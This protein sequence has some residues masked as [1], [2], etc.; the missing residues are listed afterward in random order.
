MLRRASD[1]RLVA[2]RAAANFGLGQPIALDALD[3]LDRQSANSPA[4]Q[5]IAQAS[6]ANLPAT[7][8]PS[9]S[10]ST[11]QGQGVYT[12]A[13]METHYH[14]EPVRVQLPIAVSPDSLTDDDDT[15]V[16]VDLGSNQSQVEFHYE[17]ERFGTQPQF[18]EPKDAWSL[19]SG[20]KA[21]LLRHYSRMH[22]PTVAANSAGKFYR[23]EAYYLYAL[24]R[25]PKT[26]E[27]I[28][29]GVLPALAYSQSDN[30][31]QLADLYDATQAFDAA[32]NA[33]SQ[34]GQPQ[35]GESSGGDTP[36]S[37]ASA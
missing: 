4:T 27:T 16:V 24:N 25:P 28:P 8:N 36:T 32:G 11:A 22:P 21:S 34:Q 18:P 12:V 2:L 26:N 19:D 35:G 29:V 14:R 6:A 17:A 23:T 15:C 13:R 10:L 37:G 30:A 3:A 1:R 31:V 7:P 33:S 9:T 5:V 20:L